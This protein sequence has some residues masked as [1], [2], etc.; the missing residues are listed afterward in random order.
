MLC[1]IL[2]SFLLEIFIE[3]CQFLKMMERDLIQVSIAI[4]AF[5]LLLVRSKS[6]INDSLTKHLDITG[7][8]SDLQYDFC[9]FWSTADT[10]SVPSERI[11]NL[12]DAGIL[13]LI[14]ERHSIR[15]GMPNCSTS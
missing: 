6:F 1:R 15:F 2:F 12:L 7:L 8:L 4:L 11:Y 9:A 10:L 3:L 13:H 14:S 5:F